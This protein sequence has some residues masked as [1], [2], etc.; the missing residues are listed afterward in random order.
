MN[1]LLETEELVA[2]VRN[3]EMLQTVFN[4][5]LYAMTIKGS[6]ISFKNVDGRIV[7]EF[8]YHSSFN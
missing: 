5:V 8:K 2:A 3:Q 1:K 4:L 6:E 7:S